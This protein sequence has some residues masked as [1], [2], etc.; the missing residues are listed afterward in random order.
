MAQRLV[1]LSAEKTKGALRFKIGADLTAED[2]RLTRAFSCRRW[3]LAPQVNVEYYFT[4][5]Q[6]LT[7]NV[8]RSSDPADMERLSR[9]PLADAYN[10]L[11]LPSAVIRPD[12]PADQLTLMYNHFSIRHQ[13]YLSV[14]AHARQSRHTIVPHI[15]Q[16]GTAST[17]VYQTDGTEHNAY[18]MVNVDKRWGRLP[19]HVKCSQ[20]ASYIEQ[21]SYLNGLCEQTR[22]WQYTTKLSAATHFKGCANGELTGEY[23]FS[24]NRFAQSGLVSESSQL[25][26]RGQVFLAV[27]RWKWGLSLG[28][29]Y[30]REQHSPCSQ[31]EWGGLLEYKWQKMRLFVRGENLSRLRGGEWVSSVVT[32]YYISTE[33]YRRLPGHLLGGVKWEF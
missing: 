29:R 16:H 26:T 33:R 19:L 24:R 22:L 28:Y 14:F 5:S 10:S 4:Q 6:F 7:L 18:A 32:P 3:I 31:L 25:K 2:S 20:S 17:T 27:G 15:S 23:R 12:Q 8:S 13:L 21:L 11:I 1:S 30:A 9:L